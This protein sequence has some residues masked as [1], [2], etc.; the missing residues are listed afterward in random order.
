VL[1]ESQKGVTGIWIL[2]GQTAEQI[3]GV[4]AERSA[5]TLDCVDN[6]RESTGGDLPCVLDGVIRID[7]T[8]ERFL[9]LRVSA[10]EIVP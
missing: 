9:Q 6:R 4:R 10:A 7:G 1:R 5:G 3:G 8:E 2:S